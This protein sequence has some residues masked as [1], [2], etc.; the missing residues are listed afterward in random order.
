MPPHSRLSRRR[1]PACCPPSAAL[2]WFLCREPWLS[3]TLQCP[4]LGASERCGAL[5]FLEA[6]PQASLLPGG[7]LPHLGAYP[8]EWLP[9]GGWLIFQ[10]RMPGKGVGTGGVLLLGT[11]VTNICAVPCS[12]SEA[13]EACAKHLLPG[14]IQECQRAGE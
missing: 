9:L 7:P 1:K 6:R 3:Q 4:L 10:A 12:L 2:R 14:H 11:R 13:P 5:L 8:D